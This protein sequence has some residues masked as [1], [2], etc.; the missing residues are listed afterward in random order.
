[1]DNATLIQSLRLE[2]A[3]STLHSIA[4]EITI[5]LQESGK[6]LENIRQAEEDMKIAQANAEV[7]AWGTV[8]NGKEMLADAKKAAVEKFVANDVEVQE[9][10]S[11]LQTLRNRVAELNASG[12]ASK[13]RFSAARIIAELGAAA[14][15]SHRIGSLLEVPMSNNSKGSQA[16]VPA[17]GAGAL[18]IP[19]EERE[20]TGVGNLDRSDQILPRLV[21]V[22]P[23]SRLEDAEPGQFHNS[24]LGT[25]VPEFTA[26]LLRVQKQRV[27]WP[28]G[29]NAEQDPNCASDD[30]IKPREEFSGA[31]AD[32][33][34]GCP[35]AQWGEGDTPPQCSLVYAYLLVDTDAGMPSL[36]SLTRTS[37]RTAKQLNTL[38]AAYRF[39]R[40]YHFT[41]EKVVNPKGTFYEWRVSDAGAVDRETYIS[42]ARRLAGK[43]ITVDTGGVGAAPQEDNIPF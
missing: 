33:C 9:A 41:S 21:L 22:Q 32:Q 23:T 42:I 13:V 29:Y 39:S 36:I 15:N 31:Y 28:E 37:A 26:V 40:Q 17:G 4:Q 3:V 10:R 8:P 34:A 24:V 43:P 18:S 11:R 30:N 14:M 6:I 38:F 2:D 27:F 5:G 12:E 1:M 25:Y 20:L 19:D 16:L 35:M 7:M